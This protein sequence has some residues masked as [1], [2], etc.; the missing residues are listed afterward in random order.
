MGRIHW[1]KGRFDLRRSDL[2]VEIFCPLQHCLHLWVHAGD[3]SFHPGLPVQPIGLFSKKP[4]GFCQ[5]PI[6]HQG[7]LLVRPIAQ[8]LNQVI[9]TPCKLLERCPNIGLKRRLLLL[10]LGLGLLLLSIQD[11]IQLL[12]ESR[13]TLLCIRLPSCQLLHLLSKSQLTLLCLLHVRLELLDR[14]DELLRG[15]CS[16][17]LSCRHCC[18]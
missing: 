17:S 14:V 2:G 6:V 15:H 9:L 1:S 16:L 10:C 4:V 18:K 11:L 3:E 7:H 12:P 13:F 8:R 5:A